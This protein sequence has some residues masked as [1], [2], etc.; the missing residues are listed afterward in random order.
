[1]ICELLEFLDKVNESFMETMRVAFAKKFSKA[2]RKA[3]LS[4]CWLQKLPSFLKNE[5]ALSRIVVIVKI[6]AERRP[7]LRPGLC[8]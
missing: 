8:N 2:K 6:V 1:M 4:H 5:M 7:D 3:S